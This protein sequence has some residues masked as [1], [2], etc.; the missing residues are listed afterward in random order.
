[1]SNPDVGT[2]VMEVVTHLA[3]GHYGWRIGAEDGNDF[4]V[5]RLGVSRSNG[6]FL[7]HRSSV[8][9]DCNI[10]DSDYGLRNGLSLL[11]TKGDLFCNESF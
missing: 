9:V 3:S 4:T 8:S 10:N 2:T 6:S 5:I 7:S 11:P 1:M